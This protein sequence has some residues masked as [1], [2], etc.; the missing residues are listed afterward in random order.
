[1]VRFFQRVDFQPVF[2]TKGRNFAR[3]FLFA[4]PPVRSC[5]HDDIVLRCEYVDLLE[6]LVNHADAEPQRIA[7]RGDGTLLPADEDRT[8]VWMIDA[9]K[10]I[11]K[12]C[13]AGS[14]FAK[15]GENLALLDGQVDIIIGD[16]RAK[17]LCNI[18][19]FDRKVLFNRIQ[20]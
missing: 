7:R 9:R 20:M 3:Q 8:V 10:H 14:I 5:A 19:Q 16:N 2:L 15:Q 4:Q 1:M 13:L 18:F 12:R 6:M 11:H 17:G